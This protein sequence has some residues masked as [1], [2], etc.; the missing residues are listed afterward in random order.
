M[1]VESDK[2]ALEQRLLEL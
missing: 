2:A 1:K